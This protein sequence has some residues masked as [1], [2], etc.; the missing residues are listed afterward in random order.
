MHD[1]D[2]PYAIWPDFCGDPT[3][4]GGA[5]RENQDRLAAS[6][7]ANDPLDPLVMASVAEIL[8][9]HARLQ[10]QLK[11]AE[12]R[13]Q[14][15]DKQIQSWRTAART[16][17]LTGLANRRAFHDALERQHAEWRR[18]NM[19]FSVVVMD[20]D[21]FKRINDQ[22]GHPAGDAILRLIAQV[23]GGTLRTMDMLARIGGEEFAA[24]LP[25]TAALDACCAAEHCRMAVASQCLSYEGQQLSV[26]VSLGIAEVDSSSDAAGLIARADRALYSAK[27]AGR[28]CVY[29]H[30]GQDC[31]PAVA[32]VTNAAIPAATP[33]KTGGSRGGGEQNAGLLEISRLLSKRL[34]EIVSRCH[35][36]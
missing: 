26:T 35:D 28:N 36:A 20:A 11:A 17:P 5:P 16:D 22:Y 24:I 3:Q 9:I 19:P 33:G 31:E 25:G 32:G 6:G 27:Q 14:F 34:A 10:D 7:K 15:Q 23:L 18:T 13:L 2:L 21:H 8:R 30:N 4:R 1:I 12:A 29:W